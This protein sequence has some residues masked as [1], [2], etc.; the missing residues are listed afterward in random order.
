MATTKNLPKRSALW[1]FIAAVCILVTTVASL[2]LLNILGTKRGGDPVALH[3]H[4]VRSV[5]M[6]RYIVSQEQPAA[7]DGTRPMLDDLWLLAKV[8]MIP[9]GALDYLFSPFSGT[10]L[11]A[12]FLDWKEDRQAAWV[13]TNSDFIL[14][15][16]VT[17]DLDANTIAVFSDPDLL[18]PPAGSVTYND[19][20][21]SW[22]EDW[23]AVEQQLVKQTGM[24]SKQLI[25][26]QRGLAG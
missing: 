13:R 23:P 25:Q 12:D 24:T 15:P 14:V 6:V 5:Q 22:V 26:R 19:G 17:D 3:R 10:E 1:W 20:E 8:E 4:R 16:G 2:V 7:A 18:D 11:P 21:T 9:G